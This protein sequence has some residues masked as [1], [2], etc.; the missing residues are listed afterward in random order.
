MQQSLH[1]Q[2]SRSFI[3]R[4]KEHQKKCEKETVKRH[5]RPEKEKAHQ[6]NMKSAI[7]NHCKKQ[8]HMMNLDETRV[9][10]PEHNRYQRAGRMMKQDKGAYMLS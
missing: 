4:K 5:T 6:E 10:C 7:T 3:T 9:I 8:N 2:N 1:W